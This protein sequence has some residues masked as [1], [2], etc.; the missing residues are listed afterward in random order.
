MNDVSPWHFAY[1][2]TSK[3]TLMAFDGT[4]FY[5]LGPADFGRIVQE[6]KTV[7]MLKK[8]EKM[9]RKNLAALF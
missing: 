4:D 3:N 5:I 8:I 6:K 1:N 2:A 9:D 7:F